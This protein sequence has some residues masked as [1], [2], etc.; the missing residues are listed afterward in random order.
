MHV[1][2]YIIR[3]KLHIGIAP[4]PP[5][6]TQSQSLK[7]PP[8]LFQNI[9][10]LKRNFSSNQEQHLQQILMEKKLPLLVAK[11][12]LIPKAK[13]C[14]KQQQSQ[15]ASLTEGHTCRNYNQVINACHHYF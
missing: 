2:L 12:F 6:P 10:K 4:P 1:A 11:M 13:T 5:T 14:S 8:P 7:T 3:T 9:K 15:T